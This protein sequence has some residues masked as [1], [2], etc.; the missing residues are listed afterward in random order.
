MPDKLKTMEEQQDPIFSEMVDFYFYR[1]VGKLESAFDEMMK[2][3]QVSD[4][5]RKMRRNAIVNLMGTCRNQIKVSYPLKRAN[6]EYEIIECYRVHHSTHRLPVKGGIRYSDDIN[7]D[8][9]RA[10]ATLMTW[11]CAMANIPFGGAKGGVK[12]DP[13]KYTRQEIEKITRRYAIELAKRRVVGPGID[14][15][16]PDVNTT[17]AHMAWFLDT[18]MKT[19]GSTDMNASAL[20]TGKPIS[21][22]G[23]AGRLEATGRGVWHAIEFFINQKELVDAIGLKPGLKDK[24]VVVQGFGNVGYYS[25]IHV[26]DAGAKVIG[27]AEADGGIFNPQGID[28]RELKNHWSSTGSIKGFKGCKDFKDP[29][30]VVY[31]PCDILIPAAHEKVISKDNADKIK[32]KVIAEGANGPVTPA[33]AKILLNKKVLMIPDM[34]CSAGGVTVS[35]FEWVKN[36]NHSSFGRMTFGYEKQNTLMMLGTS[37]NVSN[38]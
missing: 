34:Y 29:M 2:E 31:Q 1:A 33:G 10:L 21:M 9:V 15:P 23:V 14:V 37:Y 20:I 8:E 24:T 27:V 36:V 38:L 16:A 3:L 35:Y 30:E 28:V 18:Y 25:A 4:E 13:K 6:G 32:T 19:V 17:P 12:I 5:E 26:Q 11:K 22:G 7:M